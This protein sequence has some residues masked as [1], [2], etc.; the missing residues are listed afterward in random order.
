MNSNKSKI[1]SK[2]FS[3]G[4]ITEEEMN[5]ENVSEERIQMFIKGVELNDD[6]DKT[7]QGQLEGLNSELKQSLVDGNV[8]L[9]KSIKKK[10]QK[11]K[12][13]ELKLSSNKEVAVPVQKKLRL[14]A[15]KT[16]FEEVKLHLQE[17]GHITSLEAFSDY[18][19]QR[20]SHL[21]YRLRKEEGWGI[22]TIH[23]TK[24][25]RYGNPVTFAKYT[26]EKIK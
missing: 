1:I 4:L 23:I 2:M 14:T 5:L 25:N 10:V 6:F 3:K 18:G 21:I 26:Y 11:L 17:F 15:A 7:I 9:F 19:I 24:M 22:G 8:D 12:D 13:I 16:Q 20:L